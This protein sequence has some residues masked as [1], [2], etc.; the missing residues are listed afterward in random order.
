MLTTDHTCA[1]P[2]DGAEFGEQPRGR[3][4]KLATVVGSVRPNVEPK[5]LRRRNGEKTE[6]KASRATKPL[7]TLCCTCH[8]PNNSSSSNS[9]SR[10]GVASETVLQSLDPAIGASLHS[11]RVFAVR[12]EPAF[13]HLDFHQRDVTDGMSLFWKVP[14][15]VRHSKQSADCHWVELPFI[16]QRGAYHDALWLALLNEGHQHGRHPLKS[17]PVRSVKE[18]DCSVND[19][20]PRVQRLLNGSD[21][22]VESDPITLI[23][24]RG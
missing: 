20:V 16:F 9:S 12:E 17:W 8:Q 23:G 10:S 22:K 19:R 7:C 15:D 3:L 5:R 18:S 4:K 1:A 2:E 24:E 13:V 11:E 6:D 21:C 14:V